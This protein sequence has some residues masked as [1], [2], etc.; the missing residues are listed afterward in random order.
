[1]GVS[2][3]HLQAARLVI[4]GLFAA[5][6]GACTQVPVQ[7]PA[8][9]E[10]TYDAAEIVRAIRASGA[11]TPTELDVQPL[12]N[13]EV[14]DLRQLATQHER[15]G[16][17]QDAAAALDQALQIVPDDAAVL[18]ERSEIALLLRDAAGAERFA[19]AASRKGT[20]VG[21]LCRRHHEAL[22]R[23]ADLRARGMPADPAHARAALDARAR[24]DAC[25][26]AAPPRY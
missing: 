9:S 22:A 13:S 1:M 19:R 12:R 4:A 7:D 17:L 10:P 23:L 16:R 5:L 8:V 20:Q 24:R 15:S 2:A 14:E 3:T 11:A 21:P 6:L 18:Q 26:V 25:T